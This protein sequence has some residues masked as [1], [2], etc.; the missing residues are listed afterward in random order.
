MHALWAFQSCESEL[1]NDH[2]SGGGRGGPYICSGFV[3]LIKPIGWR[4]S[5]RV[6]VS[7][8]VFNKILQSYLSI[9]WVEVQG[10]IGGHGHSPHNSL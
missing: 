10:H 9:E 3:T 4:Q 2:F 8:N 6:Y 1:L 7:T 5:G